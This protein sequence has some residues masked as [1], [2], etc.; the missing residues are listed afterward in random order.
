MKSTKQV[1]TPGNSN[2]S[3]DA[4]T[5]KSRHSLARKVIV[6]CL[7][8]TI[9][10]PP[11]TGALADEGHMMMQYEFELS[12]KPKFR[13]I[14][15]AYRY[16]F[17]GTTA[18]YHGEAAAPGV[19]LPLYSLNPHTPGLLNRLDGEKSDKDGEAKMGIGAVLG[20]LLG[21]G[22]IA[23]Y[24]YTGVKCIQDISSYDYYGDSDAASGAC[25]AFG[26]IAN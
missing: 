17:D 12:K 7:A 26:S 15:L 6:M 19:V 25:D 8:L 24:A 11:V 21:L 2:P 22:L 16:N 23:A 9:V 14:N 4:G 5:P 18:F 3:L 20:T 10:K 13:Q 1:T